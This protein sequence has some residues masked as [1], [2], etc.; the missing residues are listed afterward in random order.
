MYIHTYLDL[1]AEVVHHVDAEFI[2]HLGLR[3]GSVELRTGV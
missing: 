3:D 1:S 2:A